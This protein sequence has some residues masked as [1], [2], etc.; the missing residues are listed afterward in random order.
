VGAIGLLGRRL[1]GDRAGI[2]AAGIAALYP[3][4]WINDAVV[5]S[6]SLL[7]LTTALMLVA[8]YAFWRMPSPWR[9]AALGA[10]IALVALTRAEGVLLFALLGVPVVL[11]AP[12]LEWRRRLERIAVM[13]LAALALVAPWVG[14]NLARFEAPAYLSTGSGVTLVDSSCDAVYSGPFIGWWSFLHPGSHL[15]RRGRQRS[16]EP[17]CRPPVRGRPHV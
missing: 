2:V 14:Y 3:F 15:E 1:A 17:R 12:G 9:A 4:L 11:M 16:G 7:A 10:A 6:E 8:A 5:L 13:A